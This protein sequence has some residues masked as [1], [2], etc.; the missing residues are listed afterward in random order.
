MKNAAPELAGGWELGL[1][2]GVER[3]RRRRSAVVHRQRHRP[4]SCSRPPM[5]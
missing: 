2:P 3:C 4:R 1:Y 5:K